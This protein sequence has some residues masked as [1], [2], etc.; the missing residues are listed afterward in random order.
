MQA[1]A[2]QKAL[3]TMAAQ[4]EHE[5]SLKIE[6][7]K[8]EHE[9]DIEKVEVEHVLQMEEN[10]QEHQFAIKEKMIDAKIDAIYGYGQNQG[11]EESQGG[12]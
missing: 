10:E 8:A 6:E 12:S 4:A 5:T 7:G 9:Q 3:Q 1:M 11:K 2:E